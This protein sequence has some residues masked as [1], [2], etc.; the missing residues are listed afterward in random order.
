MKYLFVVK[1]KEDRGTLATFETDD[2]Q[3]CK[4]IM[5]EIDRRIYNP[6]NEEEAITIE[7]WENEFLNE[8]KKRNI[9]T[10]PFVL[11]INYYF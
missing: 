8:C 10:K 6:D 4:F 9:N 3:Q 7:D 2:P 11:I 5:D 1:D